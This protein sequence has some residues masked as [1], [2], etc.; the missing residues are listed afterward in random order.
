MKNYYKSCKV[1]KDTVLDNYIK[2][3]R[4]LKNETYEALGNKINKYNKNFLE[5]INSIN[6][7]FYKL[8]RASTVAIHLIQE[9]YTDK[10]EVNIIRNLIRAQSDTIRFNR[11]FKKALSTYEIKYDTVLKAIQNDIKSQYSRVNRNSMTLISLL[12]DLG[13]KDMLNVIEKEISMT[14]VEYI[15][16]LEETSSIEK[17]NLITDEDKQA[18]YDS[19]TSYELEQLHSLMDKHKV[20]VDTTLSESIKRSRKKRDDIKEEIQIGKQV[21][22]D[23]KILDKINNKFTLNSSNLQHDMLADWWDKLYLLTKE[24]AATLHNR[25]D[26]FGVFY[27][28]SIIRL[29]DGK[30]STIEYIGNNGITDNI[31]DIMLFKSLKE[32]TEFKNTYIINNKYENEKQYTSIQKIVVQCRSSKAIIDTKI[33]EARKKYEKEKLE[34]LERIRESCETYRRIQKAESENQ[35]LKK[36]QA[37]IDIER[38]SQTHLEEALALEE[39]SYMKKELASKLNRKYNMGTLRKRLEK[40][41]DLNTIADIIMKRYYEGLGILQ[42]TCIDDSYILDNIQVVDNDES[43]YDFLESKRYY[44]LNV[45]NNGKLYITYKTPLDI[46][47]GNSEISYIKER[48]PK[49]ILNYFTIKEVK[50]TLPVRIEPYDAIILPL[51]TYDKVKMAYKK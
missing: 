10:S 51:E 23:I 38:Y 41:T 18:Y 27:Y 8:V 29:H 48:L 12:N 39:E 31:V 46:I 40:T 9:Y 43:D 24:E 20:K 3:R 49:N 7:S 47:L 6:F 13:F 44:V 28:I 37:E 35:K 11:L 2:G 4:K 42:L 14:F 19:L 36:M 15:N 1:Y 34:R 22:K 17:P 45:G 50:V 25:V 32:A 16:N 33:V 5:E 26:K 21:D 30:L